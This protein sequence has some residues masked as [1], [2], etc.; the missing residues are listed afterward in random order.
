MPELD[1][2]VAVLRANKDS[3]AQTNVAQRIEIVVEIKDA[4]VQIAEQWALKAADEKQIPKNSPLVGEEWISGPYALLSMCNGLINTLSKMEGKKFLDKLSKRDLDNGQLALKVLPV[5]IWDHLLFSGIKVEVWMEQGVNR[6]NL[7]EHAASAYDKPA[8]QRKGK[9]ALVLGAGN[10]SSIPPL[11]SFQK[12]FLENQV[13]I[14]KMNPINDYLRPIFEVALGPLISRGVLKI[15]SGDGKSGAY[16]A[17]HDDVEEIHITGSADTHDIIVWGSG[18]VGK[19]NKKSGNPINSRRITSELGA[20][21]PTIVVPGPWSRADIRFQAEHI[22]TQKMHNSGFNCVACQALILPKT[23]EKTD[24]LMEQVQNAISGMDQRAAHYPGAHERMD[25]FASRTD[26]VVKFK[27]EDSPDLVV[28]DL[29]DGNHA[30]FEGNEVFGPAMSTHRIDETDPEAYLRAA[31]SYANDSLLGTLGANIIIHPSTIA[32]IG[33]Q[34]F[35]QIIT[36]LHYGC[37][38]INGWTGIGFLITQSPW[39]AYPGHTLDDIQSGIGFVHNSNMLESPE[40]VVVSAP[41]RPFP[42]NLLSGGLTLLPKPPWFVT[43][44]TQHKTGKLLTYF[45]YKPSWLKLPR[46]FLNALLG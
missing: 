25:E 38:A 6:K 41:W 16:L 8:D 27:R 23:W 9:V 26:N 20:V 13:V 22:A 21:C 43:N 44:R 40:R 37:I 30:W 17:S 18:A 15:V 28:A 19:A 2:A 46:I 1:E 42:R 12:L 10:I 39:G 11:D 14:L 34:K 32:E 29:K 7:T 4:I 31:I 3:W 5:S 35:E 24:E 33:K 36:D 45:E